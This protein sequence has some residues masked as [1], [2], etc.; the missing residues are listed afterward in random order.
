MVEVGEKNLKMKPL[1]L[2]VEEEK[3]MKVKVFG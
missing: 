2:N 1:L 3:L